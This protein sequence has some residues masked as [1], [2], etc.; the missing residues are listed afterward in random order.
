MGENHLALP[1]GLGAVLG[2]QGVTPAVPAA[3]PPG[4]APNPRGSLAAIAEWT[5]PTTLRLADR[6]EFPGRA[7]R[8]GDG[9]PMSRAAPAATSSARFQPGDRSRLSRF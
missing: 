3:L 2:G 9:T 4:R 6:E 7:A 1:A 8:Q 5:T